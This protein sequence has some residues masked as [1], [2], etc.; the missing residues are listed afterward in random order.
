MGYVSRISA[1]NGIE[2]HFAELLLPKYINNYKLG[3]YTLR[4]IMRLP[5]TRIMTAY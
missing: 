4:K 2:N 5:Y 3:S 1:I